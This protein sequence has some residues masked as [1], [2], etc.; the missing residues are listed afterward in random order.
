MSGEGLNITPEPMDLT[1]G[2]VPRADGPPTF[3]NSDQALNPTETPQTNVPEELTLGQQMA[4]IFRSKLGTKV[5]GKIVT[6]EDIEEQ[7]NGLI[8]RGL[9]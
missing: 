7:I 2:E 6:E 5:A 4:E 9:L 8:R 1:D 3:S